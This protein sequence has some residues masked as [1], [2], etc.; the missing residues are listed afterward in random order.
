MGLHARAP[1]SVTF[2]W[3]AFVCALPSLQS[4]RW[5]TLPRRAAQPTQPNAARRREAEGS[6]QHTAPAA[7]GRGALPSSHPCGCTWPSAWPAPFYLL[8]TQAHGQYPTSAF[9]PPE[10]QR[11]GKDG[12]F[13]L[14]PSAVK[15]LPRRHVGCSGV[16][17]PHIQTHTARP[18]TQRSSQTLCFPISV[19]THSLFQYPFIP[20]FNIHSQ[21]ISMPIHSL[22]QCPFMP[23]FNTHSC[24]VS[25]FIHT[26]FQYSFPS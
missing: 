13:L 24:L 6:L 25:I 16:C 8:Q 14:P 11:Q 15:W 22:F 9:C 17:T 19:P 12:M 26:L 23:Y 2:G 20:Y 18:P 7:Q 5:E 21:L 4:F 10:T 3:D 1:T